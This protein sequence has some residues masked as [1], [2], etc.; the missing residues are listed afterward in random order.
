M[1]SV[2]GKYDIAFYCM[3]TPHDIHLTRDLFPFSL[4][5]MFFYVIDSFTVKVIMLSE[6]LGLMY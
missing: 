6:S 4:S 2:K 5:W 1:Y 3:V